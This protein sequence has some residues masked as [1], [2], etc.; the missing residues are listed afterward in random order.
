MRKDNTICYIPRE[1][2]IEPYLDRNI[3]EELLLDPEEKIIQQGEKKIIPVNNVNALFIM[4]DITF[5]K[6]FL[7]F[8]S[9]YSIPAHIFS[10]YG[11][12]RGS[13]FTDNN[14][15]DGKLIVKQANFYSDKKK[16]LA[17]A[18][19][20]VKGALSGIVRNLL[21]Y[22]FRG[23]QLEDI[24][25]ELKEYSFKIEK[26]NS[27][28]QLMQVEGCIRKIYYSA[29]NIIT[30][31]DI[32]FSK[33]QYRPPSDPMN[34]MIS[35]TNALVY[36]A[37]LTELHQTS[38]SPAVSFLHSPGKRSFTLVY[39]IAEIF[40]P[41]IADRI[42]FKLLNKK[43]IGID[44]FNQNDFSCYLNDSGRRIVVEDFDERLRQTYVH[45]KLK[46]KISLSGIIRFE[47]Y[48]LIQHLNGK[49]DY[50]SYK[51]W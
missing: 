34:A 41:M 11:K 4:T 46:R 9:Y 29:F 21:Y 36:S 38:L 7:E 12:Y 14:A 44:D 5:N 2:R 35:F 20:F 19:E 42:I 25:D 8:L 24:V 15:A 32:K 16:R 1:T 28:E 45:D 13:Y 17:I 22:K 49:N 39:D 30:D 47:C 10:Y 43:M 27:I 23:K 33:R 50:L 40:K 51:Q 6:R 31:S 3:E 26:V 18:Q 37:V 48:K